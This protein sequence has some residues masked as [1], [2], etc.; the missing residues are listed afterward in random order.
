MLSSSILFSQSYEAEGN[1]ATRF[2]NTVPVT[3]NGQN[4]IYLNGSTINDKIVFNFPGSGNYEIKINYALPSSWGN[5][6]QFVKLNGTSLG[7]ITFQNTNG[8]YKNKSLGQRNLSGNN[9]LEIQAN[10]EYMYINRITITSVTPTSVLQMGKSYNIN[11]KIGWKSL[12][13]PDPTTNGSL[14]QVHPYG[15]WGKQKWILERV[16]GGYYKIKSKLTG[17]VLVAAAPYQEGSRVHIWNYWGGAKQLWR[18]EPTHDGFVRIINKASGK[19][20]GNIVAN[21]GNGSLT[22]IRTF[23]GHDKQKWRFTLVEGQNDACPDAPIGVTGL[24]ASNG[25]LYD[26]NCNEFTMRGIN[27]Q[28]GDHVYYMPAVMKN[29]ISS[30]ANVGKANSVRLLLRFDPRDPQQPTNI[31]HIKDGINRA[32]S[33]Q[34]VPVLHMYSS[35]MTCGQNVT[36]LQVAV[37]KW[38][39]LAADNNGNLDQHYNFKNYGILNIANEFGKDFLPDYTTWKNAY[40]NA[41]TALRNAGYTNPIM[42]DAHQCGQ[43]INVFLGSDLGSTQ[44]RAQ[45]LLNHDPLRNIIFSLHAYN[46]KW[47]SRTLI[48]NQINQMTNSNLTWVFGEHGNSS[49]EGPNNDVDNKFLWE[50]CQRANPKIGWMAWSWGSGNSPREAS[51]NLSNRWVPQNNSHLTNF[52]REL[53]NHPYGTSIAQ[54]A[55]VFGSQN[56]RI[57]SSSLEE[58]EEVIMN[59]KFAVF[60]NPVQNE[61][62]VK[63]LVSGWYTFSLYDVQG[64][65]QFKEQI[66]FM[67]HTQLQLNN[68]PSGLYILQI[69]N[70]VYTQTLRVVKQ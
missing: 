50:A 49:F 57:M 23:S 29:A 34:M 68:L 31:G 60:P 64:V 17:K 43:D 8:A 27:H 21:P 4:V 20:L 42:I 22:E 37:N 25:R 38:V 24:F 61:L 45:E 11:S 13:V 30:I 54:T 12:T 51:L 3:F 52:G 65:L 15:S 41:I 1:N 5:K 48:T 6:Q 19:A 69:T 2:G 36:D 18:L 47:N 66:N 63:G 62:N 32:V 70:P 7:S 40:K 44:S 55:S 26:S 46:F 10:F 39:A 35:N 56:A 59:E 58:E 67:D 16:A 14:T 33:N 28:Y 9:T 53:V